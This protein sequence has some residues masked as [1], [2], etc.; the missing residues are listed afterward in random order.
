MNEISDNIAND[1]KIIG[2]TGTIGSGKSTVAEMIQQKGFPLISSDLNGK[3][4]M[5]N[6]PIAIQKIKNLFGEQAYNE[7]D[8]L[9]SKYI[10]DQVFANSKESA[11]LLEKLNKI[12]H[13]LVIDMMVE[14]IEKYINENHKLIFVES[15]LMFETGTDDGFDYV[16]C[17]DAKEDIRMERVQKRSGLALEQIKSRQSKQLSPEQK[18]QLADFIIENNKDLEHLKKAVEGTLG[19]I[20]I[21]PVKNFDKN[22]DKSEENED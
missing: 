17:V 9:N 6:Y 20:E 5:E 3:Y 14:T 12:V 4:I 10:S 11:I 22:F 7:D 1:V 16:I 21:M 18:K 8:K 15:A 13:P 2:I 19:I